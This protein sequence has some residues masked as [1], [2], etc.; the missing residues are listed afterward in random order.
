MI[1]QRVLLY[2]NHPSGVANNNTVLKN[3]KSGEELK[4]AEELVRLSRLCLILTFKACQDAGDADQLI[5]LLNQELIT[6]E[7]RQWLLATTLGNLFRFC[8]ST[9]TCSCLGSHL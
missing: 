2:S 6:E 9:S 7:E 4:L 1:A 5:S 3:F 8:F